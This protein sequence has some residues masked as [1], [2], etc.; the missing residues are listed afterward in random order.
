M[1]NIKP[2]AENAIIVYFEEPVSPKLSQKIISITEAIHQR[3]GSFVLDVVPAYQ[4]ILISY[5][6]D[7]IALKPFAK[8]VSDVIHNH[9]H[10]TDLD[11]SDT[12]TIPVYYSEETGFDLSRLLA[13]KKLGLER[14]I[15]LH[16]QQYYFVY[17]IG[18]SPAFAFL[19]HVEPE[20]QCKR[21]ATPRLQIPAGSV[22][23]ADNQTAVYPVESAGGWNIVGRT[24]L[25]LS[26]DNPESLD[27]FKVGKRV[28]FEPI[29]KQQFL[30][31]GGVL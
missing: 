18:F 17:A 23:I 22:G 16:S 20:I 5:R 30:D 31:L 19:G 4:S 10:L 26:L 28:K 8:R 9:V 29:N 27:R 3:L 14:F 6:F 7:L 25:D 24:P 12:V 11:I 13:E 1:F 2:A 21:L 15:E